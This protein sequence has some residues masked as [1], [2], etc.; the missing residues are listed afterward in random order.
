MLVCWS[1]S[2]LRTLVLE[3]QYNGSIRC[4][5]LLQMFCG[6]CVC[7]LAP[8]VSC[9]KMAEPIE[10]P[11]GVWTRVVLKNHVLGGAQIPVGRGSFGDIYHPTVNYGKYPACGRYSGPGSVGGRRWQC[12]LLAMCNARTVCSSRSIVMGGGL[13]SICSERQ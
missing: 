9:A 2:V 3:N 13:P 12:S 4:G 10:M 5:L 8:A 1:Y 7:L 6:L 11:F